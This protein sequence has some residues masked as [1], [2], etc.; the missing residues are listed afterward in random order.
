M[1][2]WPLLTPQTTGRLFALI[3]HEADCP[4]Q[5]SS[6]QTLKPFLGPHAEAALPIVDQDLFWS[7]AWTVLG[8]GL[9]R[10]R[11]TLPPTIPEGKHRPD[12]GVVARRGLLR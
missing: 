12:E 4:I 7:R 10:C 3:R 5:P 6:L 9:S 8:H 2:A 11:F 1:P